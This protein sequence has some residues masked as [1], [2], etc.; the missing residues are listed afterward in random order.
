MIMDASAAKFIGSIPQ[1][2]DRYLGPAWF[3]S[4][5]ADLAARMP[6]RPPG[7]VLEIA[8]GTGILTRRLRE[9]L[10]PSLRLMAT[11]LSKAMLDHARGTVRLPG[12]EW[13]EADAVRLP[14]ESAKFAAVVCSF[15]M[16]F[17]PERQA[18]FREARRV[19]CEGGLLL[20][21]VW[22]RIEENPHGTATQQLF[23]ELFPG[24][25]EMQFGKVAFG[26]HDR[27]LLRQLLSDARFKEVRMEAKRVEVRSPDAKSLATGM[28]R[29]TPRS[30]IFEKRG[31]S[32]DAM[33]EKVGAALARVGGE[34]PYRSHAQAVV[35]EARAV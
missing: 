26:M 29:G 6:A 31:V 20:C 34:K 16:M 17:I 28:V 32:L 23:D 33:I 7:N 3:E 13:E 12:I 24:D 22:D 1:Y 10:D 21:N 25:E 4:F 5:A 27:P 19:L 35:V 9:R 8:C 11:D 15:G 14:F 30:L 2:Y 18:A